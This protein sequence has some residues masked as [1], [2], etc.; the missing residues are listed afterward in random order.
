MANPKYFRPELNTPYTLALKYPQGT[1]V[2][3]QAGPELRWIL[4]DGRAFYTPLDFAQKLEAI[5]ITKA[6]QKFQAIRQSNGRT[7]EWVLSRSDSR[8][9]GP[10]AAMAESPLPLNGPQK[11]VTI[12]EQAGA[13]DA[14]GRDLEGNHQPVSEHSATALEQA[15]TTAVSAAAKAERHGQ[16]IGYTV[17][18]APGDIRAM[19]ISVL[20]QNGR[21]A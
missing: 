16:A 20:I 7:A 6:Y 15:L 3:G 18:F 5:G 17:R 19:A 1:P 12:I 10:V 21:A 11:A 8:E 2:P 14:S 13:L 4:A 9:D